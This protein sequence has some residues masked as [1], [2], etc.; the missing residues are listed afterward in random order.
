MT[1]AHHDPTRPV[2]TCWDIGMDDENSIWFH[3]TDGVRPA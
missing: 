3:Q 2:H 1:K